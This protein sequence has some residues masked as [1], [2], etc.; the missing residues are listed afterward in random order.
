MATVKVEVTGKEHFLVVSEGQWDAHGPAIVAYADG[1]SIEFRTRK[2]SVWFPAR[3][4][5]WGAY[6][7]YRVVER[8]PKPGEVWSVGQHVFMVMRDEHWVDLQTGTVA[9]GG[10]LSKGEF[11]ASSVEEYYRG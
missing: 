2:G 9:S 6:Y 3:E 5:C 1:K 8:E 11:K 4:P 10:A 7:E